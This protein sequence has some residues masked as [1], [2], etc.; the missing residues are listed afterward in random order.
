[1]PTSGEY[2]LY[3]HIPF[4]TKKCDYCHFFVLPDKEIYK[5]P[6]LLALKQEF[7]LRQKQHQ[8]P[9][10]LVSL[11]FGGGTPSLFGPARIRELIDFLP[12]AA[13]ITLEANPDNLT[14][15]L[16]Q[17]YRQAGVNRVSL[18]I[19][20]LDDTLL[21][22]I[23]RS[24]N[25]STAEKAVELLRL[26]GFENISIDLMYDLPNQ[27][28]SQWEETL[29]RAS[30]LPI[31]HLSLYNL[32]IE[33][34]TVFFKYRETLAQEVPNEELS[35]AMYERAQTILNEAGLTQ[36]EISA[37]AKPGFYSRHNTG[38]WLGRPFLGLGPSAFSFWE[39]KR[40]RNVAHLNRYTEALA[41]GQLPV[42]FEE[43]LSPNASE[44]ELFAIHLR[45]LQGAPL[46][47]FA[48]ELIPLKEA[49]LLEMRAGGVRLTPRG[50]LLY[51]SVAAE[52]I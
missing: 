34:G 51:D 22:K 50:R 5:D 13:E 28:L 23:G 15:P 16:M 12:P 27:N 9:E 4:C 42:D 49:G 45:L 7:S 1:M 52:I 29:Q 47:S 24:H 21:L 43:Q 26:A 36:Y 2:S 8:L 41:Q 10:K 37:F 48:A 20:S 46:P 6:L 40:F 44:R 32:T 17:A 33:P 19:Q 18:G 3:V 39:Q 30:R 38:Y 31:Q 25:A 11:Y 35:L 14:L